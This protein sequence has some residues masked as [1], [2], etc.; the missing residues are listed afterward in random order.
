VIVVLWAGAEAD[1]E[2]QNASKSTD[3]AKA[4][5]LNEDFMTVELCL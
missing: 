5:T 3:I 1:G 4:T 2:A